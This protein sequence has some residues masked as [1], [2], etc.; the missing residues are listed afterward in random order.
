MGTSKQMYGP[1]GSGSAD[2]QPGQTQAVRVVFVVQL[3]KGEGANFRRE[4][5]NWTAHCMATEL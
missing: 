4:A 2:I 1:E 3:P 5:K